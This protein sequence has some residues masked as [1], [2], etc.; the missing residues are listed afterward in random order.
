MLFLQCVK[1]GK[2]F[3]HANLSRPEVQSFEEG[4]PQD[5]SARAG[6][7][8]GAPLHQQGLVSLDHQGIGLPAV[9]RPLRR[10]RGRKLERH[11]GSVQDAH[12]GSEV[13]DCDQPAVGAAVCGRG[14]LHH[15]VG[16]LRHRGGRL[17]GGAPAR[18]GERNGCKCRGNRHAGAHAAGISASPASDQ[19]AART[20]LPRRLCAT[21]S[22]H[23]PMAAQGVAQA[24][25]LPSGTTRDLSSPRDCNRSFLKALIFT[26]V[27]FS[28]R[29]RYHLGGGLCDIRLL[30][31]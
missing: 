25:C 29:E 30:N 7:R 17:R 19:W 14:R 26:I 22:H 4:R 21:S 27:M 24:S 10:R 5:R 31:S 13:L 12:R 11:V 20:G 16:G 15:A 23:G 1:A 28:A 9:A 18:G 3:R 6:Q 8:R 2:A